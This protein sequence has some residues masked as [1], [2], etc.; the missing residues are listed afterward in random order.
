MEIDFLK[1]NISTLPEN[2]FTYFR[3]M[4]YVESEIEIL[5]YKARFNYSDENGVNYFF[6]AIEKYMKILH[7][8]IKDNRVH[9]DKGEVLN[10]ELM[11][12]Y[13]ISY[14]KGFHKGYLNYLEKLKQSE[15]FN[16]SNSDLAYKIF[17]RVYPEFI[18]A[19]D[20]NITCLK[21]IGVGFLKGYIT[22]DLYFNLGIEGGE[23]Y[24]A[25]EIILSNPMQFVGFFDKKVE[26]RETL[27]KQITNLKIEPLPPIET[28]AESKTFDFEKEL[29]HIINSENKFWKGLP[30]KN[31][32]E[33]FKILTEKKNKNNEPYL[34]QQQFVSFLKKGFLNDSNQ[35]IQ[36]INC[37]AG[38]KGL[39]INRFYGLYNL[40]VS[41]YSHISKKETFIKLFVN[42]FDNWDEQTVKPF[43]KPNKTKE[44]W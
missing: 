36:K 2:I 3:S 29:S 19:K 30:M 18:G 4:G 14:A 7:L 26:Q 32:V 13:F 27:R 24:K 44:K 40:A 5:P 43:F 39:I 20:G 28:K 17:E 35:S 9:N 38:E 25:W 12:D 10:N 41:Q 31:V 1:Y 21:Y 22:H 33:H 15:L 42:C 37:S 23:Y 16:L 6:Y 34:T 11:Q 8:K